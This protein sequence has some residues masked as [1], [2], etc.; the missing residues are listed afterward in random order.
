MGD[1]ESRENGDRGLYPYGS[2]LGNSILW[3]TNPNYDGRTRLE[4]REDYIKSIL[5]YQIRY[6]ALLQNDG[7]VNSE[8]ES[9]VTNELKPKLE[10]LD[11]EYLKKYYQEVRKRCQTLEKKIAEEK[12]KLNEKIYNEII[13][14]FISRIVPDYKSL[15]HKYE[16]DLHEGLSIK[17]LAELTFEVRNRDMNEVLEK[18]INVRRIDI[19]DVPFNIQGKKEGLVFKINQMFKEIADYQL[20]LGYIEKKPEEQFFKDFEEKVNK[21]NPNNMQKLLGVLYNIRL[22]KVTEYNQKIENEQET[23]YHEL[24]H[25]LNELDPGYNHEVHQNTLYGNGTPITIT[26]PTF[27]PHPYPYS[28]DIHIKKRS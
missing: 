9:K 2:Y 17:G 15:N 18:D 25:G 23:L 7:I 27:I 3:G 11:L 12:E 21:L 14:N 20:K 8:L 10:K 1:L 4:T 19:S 28:D 5:R 6:T 16:S 26:P 13:D 24:M 22:R